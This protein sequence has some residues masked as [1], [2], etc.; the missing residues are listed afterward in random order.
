MLAPELDAVL[1]GCDFIFSSMLLKEIFKVADLLKAGGRMSD[2]HDGT[3][4]CLCPCPPKRRSPSRDALSLQVTI[5]FPVFPGHQL[6][7]MPVF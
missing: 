6:L 3:V 4:L 1:H 7:G 5:D 2:D